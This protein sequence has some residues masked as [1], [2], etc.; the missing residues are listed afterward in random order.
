M[1]TVGHKG[2]FHEAACYGDDEEFLKIAVPFVEGGLH[3]G[4]PTLVACAAHNTALI[5]AA[6]GREKVVTFLPGADQYARPVD[7]IAKYRDIFAT[8]ARAGARQIR[9]V[10]DVPHP[11]TGAPWNWWARYEAAVNQAYAEFPVWGLCPYDTRTTPADV[12]DDVMRTHPNIATA[13]GHVANPRFRGGFPRS[14]PRPDVLQ[15]GP[16]LV[17][18]TDP[19]P[20]AVRAAVSGV[21]AGAGG[22]A[23]DA[24]HDAVYAASELVTNGISHGVAPVVFRLWASESRVVVTV[25]DRGSGP[26]DPVAG[27]MPTAATRTAGLGLWILH[28]TCDDVSM[29]R[30]EHGFTA[31]V[32]VGGPLING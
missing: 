1:R 15:N 24:L 11:G 32:V 23:E 8:H 9:V 13:E 19:S 25:S 28:R 29:A 21:V 18:L 12:L 3:A 20:A 14:A 26:A 7:A 2:F 6:L 5:R 16:A 27:L 30:D 31:R 4:E 10:G 22:L 17:E